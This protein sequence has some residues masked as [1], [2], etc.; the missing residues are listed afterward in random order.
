MNLLQSKYDSSSEDSSDDD[1]LPAIP[2]SVLD[3]YHIGP[4]FTS[5]NSNKEKSAMSIK[6]SA[7][8]FWN[9]FIYLEWRPTTKDRQQLFKLVTYYTE[10]FKRNGFPMK[11]KPLY[12]SDL[13]SPR[14][15]HVSITSNISFNNVENRDRLLERL[16]VEIEKSNIKP[17]EMNFNEKPKLMTSFSN[18]KICFMVLDIETEIKKK[19]II[20]L[21]KIIEKCK[22]G[23]DATP[24]FDL[25][26]LQSH[27]SIAQVYSK[28]NSLFPEIETLN[29]IFEDEP[30]SNVKIPSFEVNTVKFDKNRQSLSIRLPE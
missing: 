3:K 13:G 24:L 15:L 16:K 5:A 30:A 27:M 21:Y 6:S 25:D 17:F 23:L 2:S 11:I 20:Q 19:Y 8:S 18:P 22:E 9:T 10:T 26:I 28:D 1:R 29:Q 4:S 12:W 7:K 14:S